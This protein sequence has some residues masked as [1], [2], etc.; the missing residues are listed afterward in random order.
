M[1][2]Y[3]PPLC[4]AHKYH[5]SV[6]AGGGRKALEAVMLTG[7]FVYDRL[8]GFDSHVFENIFQD[9]FEHFGIEGMML[10]EDV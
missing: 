3:T 7:C 9:V 4:H 1:D 2:A 10:A 8:R 6:S 5:L